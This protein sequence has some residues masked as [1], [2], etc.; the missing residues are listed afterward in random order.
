[1]KNATWATSWG[2]SIETCGNMSSLHALPHMAERATTF[3]AG[4]RGPNGEQAKVKKS[5]FGR[6]ADV[7]KKPGADEIEVLRRMIREVTRE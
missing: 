1:M 7:F 2:N 4:M 5:I 3:A 6:F